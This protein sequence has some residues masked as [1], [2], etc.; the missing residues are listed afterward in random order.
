MNHD[1][2]RP[3]DPGSAS[4]CQA[5]LGTLPPRGVRGW[6]VALA[7]LAVVGSGIA[8]TLGQCV[9]TTNVQP[10]VGNIPAYAVGCVYD[11][12]GA[13]VLAL[14]Q[15]P[16][17]GGG[18][19]VHAY[20]GL[21]WTTLPRL[22]VLPPGERRYAGIWT[23]DTARGEALLFGGLI[24]SVTGTATNTL[25][26]F[27][28]GAW[29]QK[30]WT[31]VNPP[32]DGAGWGAYDPRRGRT[33]YLSR[34]LATVSNYQTWEWTGTAWEQGPE[35]GPVSPEGFIF[36]SVRNVGFMLGSEVSSSG[37]V[38]DDVWEYT[39]PPPGAHAS[40]G[41][42]QRIVI[43]PLGQSE[44]RR[45]L[46]LAYDPFRGR[47][48]RCF[49]RFESS[50][51]AWLPSISV[52]DPVLRN[53]SY[54]QSLDF[55]LPDAARRGG[56][57]VA[58]D[59]NRDLLIIT[60]GAK[61]ELPSAGSS[62]FTAFFD[63]WE[64]RL[65]APGL[66]SASSGP[67]A[68]CLSDGFTL[69][70]APVGDP[71]TIQW[72]RN[73]APVG[74]GQFLNIPFLSS[75]DA[76]EYRATITNACGT[77]VTPAS[78]LRVDAP[79]TFISQTLWPGCST[80]P[81]TSATIIP[82]TPSAASQAG[83]NLN[84]RLQKY[85]ADAWTDVQVVAPGG[86]FLL[87]NLQRSD[88]G[89]YRVF[90]DGS[91][92]TGVVES[93]RRIDV[94]ISFVSQP[95][96]QTA[97]PCAGATFSV[98]AR[99]T[100]IS[101]FQWL[102]NGQSI[103]SDPRY[104]GINTSDLTIA[105]CR[106]EDEGSYQCVITDACE[107]VVSAAAELKLTTPTWIE[108]PM[109]AV[110]PFAGASDYWT[111]A[112]DEHR[113][114]TILYGGNTQTGQNSNSLWEYDGFTWTLRQ[115]GYPAVNSAAGQFLYDGFYPPVPEYSAMVYCPDDRKVYL[116]GPYSSTRPL[117]IYTW[118]G[119]AWGRPYYGPVAGNIGR[120]H[121][122]WDSVN[123]RIV[124]VRAIS[125]SNN[126]EL[127][128]FDPATSTMTG[129]IAM[130]PGVQAGVVDSALWF[131]QRRGAAIWYNN[132][133]QFVAPTMWSLSAGTQWQQIP[134]TPQIL[135]Y[136]TPVVYDPV[137]SQGVGIGGQVDN[138]THFTG[139]T[140]WPA[141]QTWRTIMPAAN[142]WGL[143]NPD[144][145]PR[146]PAGAGV[147]PPNGWRPT[148]WGGL[149]F[150]AKRRALFGVGKTATFNGVS[151]N[152]AWTA[153]ERRYLDRVVFDRD[154]RIE[155][156]PS[157]IVRFSAAAAGFPGL[158]YQWRR[159]GMPIANGPSP[160]GGT[161]SGTQSAQ[162]T[163]TNAALADNGSY[164]LTVTNACG[165]ATSTTI[166]LGCV[167]DFNND[168]TSAVIDILDFLNAWFTGDLAADI[169]GGGLSSSDIFDFL[170]AWFDGC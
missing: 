128:I 25:F 100:C 123:R 34:N 90:V 4:P 133:N 127:L 63:T 131:D 61:Q 111:G 65:S 37:V 20:D 11:T 83:V 23:Y 113:G 22:G 59:T 143:A 155:T 77:I 134:G 109:N 167:S 56:A 6:G 110:P 74:T 125:G 169:N 98:R 136:A 168:G 93:I 60:G 36:D 107:Q 158:T 84:I 151:F 47:I 13:R 95:Q 165:A 122:V 153:Y 12:A 79:I 87:S 80:C 121:A 88:S 97:A 72:T 33:V 92:C 14:S 130:Q 35:F 145:P 54:A 164:T 166:A 70:V 30:S 5:A 160:S 69:A 104:S 117:A 138:G 89:D 147:S 28:N 101:S 162:L 135:S 148:S 161:Y 66:A 120:T 53:W 85:V 124:I 99:G 16:P 21:S 8:S 81:G 144:G 118:D 152:F 64:Q 32:A 46:T 86:V 170:N 149:T 9:T 116:I 18:V 142:E 156:L 140:T 7:A 129:P 58:Y 68:R 51:Y 157:N 71:G 150:D 82:A 31:G 112:F 146:N 119:T 52:W 94:G 29:E 27:R 44:A 115:D 2:H 154:P 49:G 43:P 40:Q 132:L 19:Q 41:S 26:A 126:T 38:V 137:R 102:K 141:G 139:T 105:G 103:P 78:T 106:Y 163:L 91:A 75:S 55:T 15:A 3:G 48:L 10:Q 50:P 159:N 67:V 62:G 96:P 1:V 39:P 24:G 76:G 108:K 42:W 114:V 17:E 45:S 57:G 73:G